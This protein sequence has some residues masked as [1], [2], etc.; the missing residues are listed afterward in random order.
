VA[1]RNVP[2]SSMDM[3]SLFVTSGRYGIAVVDSYL[4]SDPTIGRDR[5]EEN[6]NCEFADRNF[7]DPATRVDLTTPFSDSMTIDNPHDVDWIRFRVPGAVTQLVTFRTAPPAGVSGS[8]AGDIDL[9]VMAIPVAGSPL[10][11]RGFARTKGSS[12]SL[13]LLLAPGEYYM[14]VTDFAG[15]PIRYS[16]CAALG[17]SCTMPAG[18]TTASA[19]PFMTRA[20]K[21]GE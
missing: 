11:V 4:T 18:F 8:R 1:L 13:S 5:L 16:L 7:A 21:S 19:Q 17:A 9:A 3:V 20:R 6:D 2:A 12:E 14:V 15:R 10:D